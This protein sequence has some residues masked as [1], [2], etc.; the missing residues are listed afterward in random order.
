MLYK[1]QKETHLA[2][3]GLLF[4]YTG[5]IQL[6]DI[7]KL[8]PEICLEV[9]IYQMYFIKHDKNSVVISYSHYLDL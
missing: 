9:Y 3:P 2:E 7:W 8:Y 6:E 4:I 5:R 1:E